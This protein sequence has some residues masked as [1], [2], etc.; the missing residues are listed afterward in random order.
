M[1]AHA[2]SQEDTSTEAGDGP[3]IRKVVIIGAGVSGLSAA[4]TLLKQHVSDFVILECRNRIGGRVCGIELGGH[5][6][7]LGASWIHGILGNPLYEM[8]LSHKLVDINH[9][10]KPRNVVALTE[11]GQR[12]PFRLVQEIYDAYSWFF[13][14]CEEYYLSRYD[15]PEG[16]DSVGEH[17]CLEMA[18]YLQEFPVQDQKIRRMLFNHLL[19]RET[20]ITGC[21]SMHEMNLLEIGSYTELPGGNLQLRNGYSAIIPVLKKPIPEQAMRLKHTVTKIKWKTPKASASSGG[22][23]LC[24][25]DDED[26]DTST[27]SSEN[28]RSTV[29][30]AMKLDLIDEEDEEQLP[31]EADPVPLPPPDLVLQNRKREPDMDLHSQLRD[32][33]TKAKFKT[34]PQVPSKP[35]PD[36]EEPKPEEKKFFVEVHCA[37][38]KRFLAE[39]V[40]C[41]VPLGVLKES[42]ETLFEPSLPSY[43]LQAIQALKFGVVNKIY[44]IYS[45]P[46]LHRDLSEIIILWDDDVDEAVTEQP[47]KETW[48]RRIYSFSKVTEVVIMAW[49]AGK[50]AEFVETLSSQEI[51]E[52]CTQMLRNF[53][54]DPT[55]WKKQPGSRGSYTSIPVGGH[56]VD[57]ESLGQPLYSSPFHD[58]PTLLFAGE[59]THPSFYSTVHGAFMT[60]RDAAEALASVGASDSRPRSPASHLTV[61]LSSIADLS[62]W[63]RGMGIAL[64]FPS[65]AVSFDSERILIES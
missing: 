39:H 15:P 43:K 11:A 48:H 18:L 25:D 24:V 36:T 9:Q 12:I 44:L 52:K 46:F 26:F 37:N 32:L 54:N 55:S 1:S 28:S 65:V 57:I 58:L 27:E 61:E 22:D 51:S 35:K 41:C 64:I 49:V 63:V 60:G 20:V 50:A 59:H 19:A 6:L 45:R 23:G 62:N 56:Q 16:I 33:I 2:G 53:L 47:L 30:D 7:E 5:H 13:R 31:N 21:D 3:E 17:L 38:G 40:I 29:I 8:A 34:K 4:N 42:A 14:R 10:P